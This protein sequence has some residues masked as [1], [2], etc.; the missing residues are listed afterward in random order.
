MLPISSAVTFASS[1]M[2]MSDVPAVIIR[3]FP[4]LGFG[5]CFFITI[6]F[7]G[8]LYWALGYCFFIVVYVFLSAFVAR[9]FWLWVDIV[10]RILSICVVVL[11]FE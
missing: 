1:A 7:A 8:S 10:F 5:V 2:G 6:V 4:F 9:M 11:P 3:I